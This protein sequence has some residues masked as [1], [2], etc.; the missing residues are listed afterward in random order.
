MNAQRRRE[1]SW[2]SARVRAIGLLA[3]LAAMTAHG[4]RGQAQITP[5]VVNGSEATPGEYPWQVQ[6]NLGGGHW[7]GGSLLTSTWVLTAAHCVEGFAAADFTATVGE[8]RFGWPD[9]TEQ[10]RS[11]AQIIK[12]PRFSWPNNDVA[13]LRLSSPVSFNGSVAPI[14]IASGDYNSGTLAMVSGW[15]NTSPGSGPSSVL[16]EA[17]LPIVANE[18]CAPVMDEHEPLNHSMLCA[19]V[20]GGVGGCHGDSGGPLVV[21]NAAGVRELIGVVSWGQGTFCGK[22]TVFARARDFKPWV[23]SQIATRP[24]VCSGRSAP[25]DTN[26]I[27]NGADAIYADIDT[28]PCGWT[29]TPLYFSSLG[30]TGSHL[31]IDGATSIYS[32]TATGFRVNLFKAGLNVTDAKNRDYHVNWQSVPNNTIAFGLCTGKSATTPWV[33][34]N[35]DTIYMD[36]NTSACGMVLTPSYFTSLN[37]SSA[38][39]Q[40]RGATAI[41]SPTATGF[42]VY[43]N[44]SGVTP[45]YAQTRNWHIQWRAETPSASFEDVCNGFTTPGSTNWQVHAANTIV[46]NVNT[47]A[48]SIATTPKL[49]TSLGGTGGHSTA[50]GV[51][52]IYSPTPDGF[53]VYISKSGITPAI[54]N[55]NS[56]HVR[57]NALP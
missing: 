50:R 54:A 57:W 11:V 4:S 32:P 31:N 29:S 26:W 22:Y 40:T 5:Q 53:R 19:G 15:G 46:T 49:F 27:Q 2:S 9:L 55:Q 44:R 51:T 38:H 12:H 34:H 48:C 42:R 41:Y 45:A 25:G 3:I 1:S 35:A 47:S 39:G 24:P 33:Q 10:V 20:I 14:E 16:M 7:C 6:L 18:V 28:S 30:G 56:F 23:E 37:G 17:P 36:V 13:L 21:T 43:V 8:H 52:S